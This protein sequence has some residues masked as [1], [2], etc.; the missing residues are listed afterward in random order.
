M[1][2]EMLYPQGRILVFCKAPEPGKVKTRLAKN[3]GDE[4]AATIHE[5]L[6]WHCLQ[7]ISH[8]N[9]APIELWCAPN[10]RHAFFQ[11]CETVFGVT[12]KKQV[13]KDLGERMGNAF[14]DALSLCRYPLIIGT[15]CPGIDSEYLMAAFSALQNNTTVI[16][17]AED[18]GYVL[19]G[20]RE[21]QAQ[22]FMDMPWGSSRVFGETVA[23]LYGSVKYLETRWDV[24]RMEDILRLREATE[25]LQLEGDFSE[26]IDR[27]GL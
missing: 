12:L 5:Y 16:A 6:A 14:S 11:R 8:Q 20:L 23:R 26:Y 24:D 10:I 13:G 7:K 18:G 25:M 2:V 22:I 1:N 27:L 9:I 3:I 17:P 15:D 19:I 4:A 21:V